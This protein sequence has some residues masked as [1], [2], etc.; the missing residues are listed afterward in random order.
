MQ[1]F[2]AI[3][4]MTKDSKNQLFKNLKFVFLEIY[5]HIFSQFRPEVI[6]NDNSEKQKI[7]KIE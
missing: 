7:M 4:F 2:D 1:V 5:Y 6:M 3:V